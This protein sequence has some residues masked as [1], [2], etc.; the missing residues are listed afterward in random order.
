[1]APDDSRLPDSTPAEPP[2]PVRPWALASRI[3][4]DGTTLR[5]TMREGHWGT[6]LFLSLWL[7]GWTVGCVALIWGVLKGDQPMLILFGVPFWVSWFFVATMVANIW[8]GR[9]RLT[10]D[11]DGL[12]LEWDVIVPLARRWVPLA[13]LRDVRARVFHADSEGSTTSGIEVRTLGRSVTLG[14]ALSALERNW[15]AHQLEKRVR[16]LRHDARLADFGAD[17]LPDCRRCDAPSDGSWTLS[18][19]DIDPT[20][21]QRGRFSL[22]TVLGLMFLNGFW[23]GIVG[24]FVCALCGGMEG[25][26]GPEGASWWWLFFFLIPFEAIGVAMFVGLLFALLEPFRVTR[27]VFGAGVIEHGTTRFG[28]PLGWYSRRNF[29][30][31]DRA[32]VRDDLGNGWSKATAGQGSVAA[33]T[34]AE[35]GLLVSDTDGREVCSIRG[36]SLGEAR[37]IK[38]RLQAAGTLPIR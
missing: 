13:E 14:T 38:G 2:E 29:D 26:R 10:L 3:D 12:L 6:G 18:T 35:Y 33:P 20:L 28:L 23:N 9:R 21:W 22:S 31:L 30:R 4:D 15:V 5:L 1:M 8:C 27:W 34:G 37:W 19:G 7:A 32:T 24:V 36:L 16:T 11:R 17:D 25:D